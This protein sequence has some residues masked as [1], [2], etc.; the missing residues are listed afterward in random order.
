MQIQQNQKINLMKKILLPLLIFFAGC[1]NSPVPQNTATK[2]DSHVKNKKTAPRTMVNPW[3]VNTYAAKSG[4]SAKRKYVRFDADGNFS[5]AE[6]SKGYL[7]AV[8]YVDKV[9]AGIF[10]HES[11]KTSPAKKFSGP[12]RITMTNSAGEVLKMTST[13]GWNKSMG[14]LI[15]R[16]NS[17]YSQFRIFLLQASGVINVEIQDNDSSVYHF[18]INADGFGKA[19]SHI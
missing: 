8:I 12:V 11:G 14:I 2:A 6:L 1:T 9:N 13:R 10:L 15:E 17:D 3:T 7:Y 18:D 19:F 5:N 4:E 16:N